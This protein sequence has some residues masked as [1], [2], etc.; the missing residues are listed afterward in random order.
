MLLGL[1]VGDPEGEVLG[2]W[3]AKE[4]VRDVYLADDPTDAALLLDK[5]IGVPPRRGAG[6][7]LP[8][9]RREQ[10]ADRRP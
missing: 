8:R 9:H 3:V 6:D 4:S 1:Q 7:P 2:A 5:T 10:R